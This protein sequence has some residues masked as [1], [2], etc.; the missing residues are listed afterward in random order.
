MREET[1][2][3]PRYSALARAVW[4]GIAT[5]SAGLF[6]YALPDRY[7]QLLMDPYNLQV[8]LDA[9]GLRLRHF[10]TYVTILDSLVAACFLGGAVLL[11]WR[12]R[13]DWMVWLVTLALSTF[14]IGTLPVTTALVVADPAWQTPLSILRAMSLIILMAA[15][16]TFPDGRFA[17]RWTWLIFFGWVLYS[18]AWLFIPNWAPPTAIADLRPGTNLLKSIP[19]LVFIG[20]VVFS[21]GRRY[22]YLLT[23]LQRQQT[24]WV[25]VGLATIFIAVGLFILPVLLLE[26]LRNS[27]VAFTIYLLI[28]VP[29]VV[30][31]FAL[32]PATVVLAVARYR[33][34]DIDVI[35]R[36]TIIYG[37][38]S[39]TLALIYFALVVL[40]QSI[41]PTRSPIAIVISTLIIATLFAPL[42]RRIQNDIDRRFFRRK[43]DAEKAL[44]DFAALSRSEVDI[45]RL[46][47][48]LLGVVDDTFQPEKLNLWMRA[49]GFPANRPVS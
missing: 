37:A 19:P 4:I 31:T 42:R 36:R 17:P 43:Y 26:A 1:Q 14:L 25:V 21:Q 49:A 15:L 27:P 44:A 47:G 11:Y 16:L 33:L 2:I 10:A 9:L 32:F 40:L 18:L 35:I 48:A 20:L 45:E 23:P 22:R 29:I 7:E 8:G 38:L 34:W 41:L 30:V 28:V 39:A 6:V 46:E 13:D 12:K 24:R 5:I 3:D